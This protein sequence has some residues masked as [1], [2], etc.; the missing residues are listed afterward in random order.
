MIPLFEQSERTLEALAFGAIG[1]AGAFAVLAFVWRRRPDLTMS[2]P[3]IAIALGVA[4]LAF[5]PED[6]WRLMSAAA[7]VM[8]VGVVTTTLRWKKPD[9]KNACARDMDKMSRWKDDRDK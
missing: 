2:A 3:A 5:L 8:A 1:A 7:G 9:G 6:M 4:C